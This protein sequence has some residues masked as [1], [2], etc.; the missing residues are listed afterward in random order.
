[1]REA[2][3]VAVQRVA[4]HGDGHN[5]IDLGRTVEVRRQSLVDR[6]AADPAVAFFAEYAS[7]K[8]IAAVA[9]GSTGVTHAPPP[10]TLDT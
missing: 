1:M 4:A 3:V 8:L 7:A 2:T 6:L 10:S 5:L 9:V